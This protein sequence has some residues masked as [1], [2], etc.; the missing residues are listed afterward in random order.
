[1]G[2]L[3]GIMQVYL[4]LWTNGNGHAEDKYIT[5]KILL[6]DSNTFVRNSTL[7]SH[8][9][10]IRGIAIPLSLQSFLKESSNI[11]F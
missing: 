4:R 5:S 3:Y 1:M 2:G 11:I 10:D 7:F 9:Y 6:S 8:Q